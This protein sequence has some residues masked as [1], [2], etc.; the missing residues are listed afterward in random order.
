MLVVTT[1]N[2][3]AIR[4]NMMSSTDEEDLLSLPMTDRSTAKKPMQGSAGSTMIAYTGVVPV[5]MGGEGQ[6]WRRC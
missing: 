5:W 3:E 2:L 6:E 4:W 1:D